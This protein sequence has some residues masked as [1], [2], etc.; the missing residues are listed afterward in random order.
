MTATPIQ[1][2][3]ILDEAGNNAVGQIADLEQSIEALT[4]AADLEKDGKLEDARALYQDVV[5]HAEDDFLRESAHKALESLAARRIAAPTSEPEAPETA[6]RG[7]VAGSEQAAVPEGASSISVGKSV[8]S[9]GF[10]NLP[11]FQKQLF[12]LIG[13]QVIS[14]LA[15]GGL[16]VALLNSGRTQQ[17]RSQAQSELAVTDVNYNI[18]INQMGFGFRGQSDNAAII[19]AASADAADRDINGELQ[20]QVKRILQNEIQARNIE[21]ATLVGQDRR[22]IASAN[23]NRDGE[24]FD[25]DGLVSEVFANPAQIKTSQ[26]VPW[27]ELRAENPPLPEGIDGQ[28]ALVR[29]TVTPVKANDSDRVVGALVSGDI[30]NGKPAIAANTLSAFDG[31]Y[32]AVYAALPDG[33]FQLATSQ[34]GGVNGLQQSIEL[35]NQSVLEAAREASGLPAFGQATLDGRSFIVAAEAIPDS[36]GDPVA[37][38]VRGTPNIG[39]LETLS[40]QLWLFP[41][42]ALL[43]VGANILLARYLG[44]AIVN[45]VKRLQQASRQFSQGDR[46]IRA[47]VT[48]V[49]E[50]GQLAT[51]FNEMADSVV[52]SEAEMLK[53]AG[54]R[55]QEANVQREAKA[56]L[57]EGIIDFLLDIESA[58]DG[59]LTVQAALKEGEMG[60]IADA[61][62]TTIANL[63]ELVAQVQDVAENVQSSASSNEASVQELS[64]EAKHQVEAAMSALFS[65]EEMSQAISSVAQSAQDTAEVARQALEFAYNGDQAMSQTVESIDDIR[66]SVADTSKK[67]KRL[68]ESSQEISKIVGIIS[69]I[70]EKTNLLAFNASIEAARAGENGQGFRVVADEVRR[71]AERVTEATKDIEQL[72]STIQNETAEVL[73]TMEKSTTQVVAGTQQVT[74]TKQTLRKLAEISLQIDALVQ[75]ITASTVSQSEASQVMT[76]TMQEVSAIA[77]NTSNRSQT[78]STSLQELVLSARMLQESTAQFQVEEA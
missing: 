5:D 40:S 44:S 72:V 23:A 39:L 8:Q 16:G 30:V 20:Q 22:I 56:R 28:D 52:R 71:L 68:A 29:Y 12:S 18:K 19:E 4:Q 3:E 34:L 1:S 15:I 38:L 9:G 42:T 77:Q 7:R 60:T 41:A 10:A 54:Q 55:Q 62:N 50:I 11:I 36:T 31:G 78:V 76:Q 73:Q 26:I 47:Q 21:Y 24:V 2:D 6:F 48:T 45:P 49:E 33:N 66:D 61:F 14:V 75:G 43:L 13:V 25:P 59:D 35:P 17:L 69:S 64:D 67:V 32:S 70:S 27:S 46:S 53:L 57:Q 74:E 63:R 58:R 65:A 51:S 37:L